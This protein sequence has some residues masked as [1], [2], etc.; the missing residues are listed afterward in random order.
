MRAY[1]PGYATI[2]LD[3][4]PFELG[5]GSF[6]HSHRPS[7]EG[8]FHMDTPETLL[9]DRWIEAEAGSRRWSTDGQALPYS[10]LEKMAKSVIVPVA[11][12]CNRKAAP[13]RGAAWAHDPAARG[14]LP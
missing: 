14:C 2:A 3:R 10:G 4:C 11:S 7:S 1:W 12:I 6:R 9:L 5:D 8:T 13:H